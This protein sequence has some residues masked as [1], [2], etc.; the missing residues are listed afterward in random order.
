MKRILFLATLGA[1]FAVTAVPAPA[2]IRGVSLRD[3]FFRPASVTVRKGDTVKFRW[4]GNA[5]HNVTVARGPQ[6]FRS[7]TKASGSYRKRM[8]RRG[9]YR[10]VCTVHS[11][12]RMTLR[13]R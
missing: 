11:G 13:V 12:M 2:A 8:T 10:L 1:M 5:S 9:T 6:R 7:G 4:L 3:N